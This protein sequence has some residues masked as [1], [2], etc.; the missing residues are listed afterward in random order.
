MKD[1]HFSVKPT[2]GVKQQALDVIRQL[3]DTIP[4]ERAQMSVR[5]DRTPSLRHSQG[6]SCHA[7]LFWL[8]AALKDVFYSSIVQPQLLCVSP[9]LPNGPNNALSASRVLRCLPN[10]PNPVTASCYRRRTPTRPRQRWS[11]SSPPSRARSGWAT[12]SWCVCAWACRVMWAC[13]CACVVTCV[14]S[15][16]VCMLVGCAWCLCVRVCARV[17]RD[18]FYLAMFGRVFPSPLLPLCF[19]A[20]PPCLMPARGAS[21]AHCLRPCPPVVITHPCHQRAEVLHRSGRIPPDQRDAG[22][23]DQGSRHAGDPDC[24]ERRGRGRRAILM[25]ADGGGEAPPCP[26]SAWMPAH[27]HPLDRHLEKEHIYIMAMHWRAVM[28]SRSQPGSPVGR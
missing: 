13:C 26:R 7:F 8:T 9:C 6:A 16:H 20:P 5:Y 11:R 21:D 24:Q 12:W 23:C 2:Q 19:P 25:P 28:I 14:L 10:G 22:L 15:L 3:Q 4:I 1:L 27:C 18:A 17:S